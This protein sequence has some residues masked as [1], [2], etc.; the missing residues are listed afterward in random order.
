DVPRG[1]R[2]R[3]ARES[4]AGELLGA[5]EGAASEREL[6][7]LEREGER[8]R[9]GPRGGLVVLAGDVELA[10]RVGEPGAGEGRPARAGRALRE[11]GHHGGG[12]GDVASLE[13]DAD[14]ERAR[15]GGPAFAPGARRERSRFVRT[16]AVVGDP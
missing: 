4:F 7:A 13:L 8:G 14:E 2:A 11:L 16:A 1:E 15:V 6:R 3:R 9:L 5:R 10:A 12:R